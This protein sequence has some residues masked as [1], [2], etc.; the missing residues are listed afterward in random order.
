MHVRCMKYSK[1]TVCFLT[2]RRKAS[3]NSQSKWA[4]SATIASLCRNRSLYSC[5]TCFMEE[6]ITSCVDSRLVYS[7][8]LVPLR[9][10]NKHLDSTMQPY[11]HSFHPAR[12]FFV[13]WEGL[14][15]RLELLDQKLSIMRDQLLIKPLKTRF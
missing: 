3:E 8:I 9:S 5:F 14:L 7:C 2:L 1:Q 15:N 10:F 4:T 6:F 11:I 13:S 12:R